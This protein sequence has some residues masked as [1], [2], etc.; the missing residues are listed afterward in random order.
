MT[1]LNTND[2]DLPI[3]KKYDSLNGTWDF[4]KT[5]VSQIFER[6]DEGMTITKYMELYTAIHNY[7]A[8]AS[9]T[10]TVDNFNDQT[11]NVL[12]E[13][14]YNNLVLYLEEYLAR[15]RKE[16]ISQTNHEEQLAAYAKYW[17]RFTTSARFINHL[18]G[19]LNRYWVKLKNR[20]T[21]T[22]V[23]DI[24]TLCLVSWHHH[25]FSHICDSLLQNLLYMF[26]KKRL[27]EPTDMKYVEVCV[28]SITSLS[29]DKTDMTK[30]NLS[31]YKTFF[32]TNFIENTKNFYAK[33]SSEYLASHSITDYLKKAEIRLAEEEELVRLYL[34][35][36]TLKPLLE[37]TEDVLIAQHEEVLHNDFAR[38]LD[39]NCSEDIIRM[40]RLMSRTPNGLQPLRQ[41][42]EEFVKRSGFAAVAKI[43]P[44]VGGEADVDPKEYM[45]MLLSTY[46]ASK[47]LVNTAFHG[48]TDFT[49]SLDT[50]F[51]ELVNRNVVC[52]RSSSRSPE[53]LAK[54]ADSILRKSNKN[55]D[56]DDVEDCL[57]SII[58][59][60]RYVEDKDVF[61]NFYT[62]LL[63]KR[64]VNGTSN[65]QDAESSMLSKLKEVCGFEYT[66]KLQRMFQDISLSQEITEAFWQLPQS[67]AGNIDFSALVLGTS[68][69]PL[70][71]NNVNFHLPEELVPLYEG[72]QN[73]YYSCHNGRKLSWLFHLS[74]GEIKARINPQ[75]NVTYVFQV[76]TY[77]MGVLLLYNHRDSYTYEELAKITGLSTDFLTG[78]LNI[79]LKAKVLLLGDNDKL[80][81][82]N[83][84]YKINENFR[85]KKIRVQLNLPIRSEQK[86]ESLETHKT[87]EEDRKLLLQSAIVR[88]MK[89]RRTLKHVVLVKE[90]IDQIKS[91]FTPKVS[92]IKQ[93]IDMLIE[94]EY[95]ERQG[96]DE[97]IYLA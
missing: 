97:Y 38:M 73:Y 34:H 30:P 87:I 83:S 66:S 84:T 88:I 23:Y 39:Q 61:Q 49:K 50:A 65:S 14:L 5:G 96:R 41:T 68:F 59:I 6:L 29:F 25:V 10:I 64:L 82:P 12:G 53:L 58:I 21:E 67:R 26:T 27:Y 79:F 15:L 90:T 33:E 70:S 69:W 40:Y 31:S 20:F 75:T 91:R 81:D 56:I 93:C 54:Y 4:L 9:K 72:F 37:A 32:E 48:D 80:G 2:K 71:P 8:D 42:F 1:T 60:F 17:T 7:C 22:L 51:R 3:V 16:C 85:M 57:S 77:Q 18:F 94:K 55:V 19:Y 43:V 13:A 63:A 62:K 78:I 86:Q 45:E 92:D 35:E 95:L 52:Q 44:Q 46:K 89:A 11:A 74:K 36:S 28:D 47:E 76:S 24:Y